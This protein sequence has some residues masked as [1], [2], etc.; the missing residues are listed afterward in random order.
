MAQGLRQGYVLSP[1]RFNVFLAAILLVAL[2]R[3]SKDAGILVDLI[4]HKNSRRKLALKRHWNVFGV[5][6][7]GCMLT[8]RAS[9]AGRGGRWRSSSKSSAH[10]V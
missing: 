3:F 5:L 2:E 4:H 8:T 10:L 7:R 1:L 9:R 6:F